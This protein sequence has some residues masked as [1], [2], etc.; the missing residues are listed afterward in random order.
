MSQPPNPSPPS[1][2]LS[3]RGVG[4]GSTLD[5]IGASACFGTVRCR[6]GRRRDFDPRAAFWALFS[7]FLESVIPVAS[8]PA[9]G[10]QMLSTAPVCFYNIGWSS[11]AACA[12]Y[13]PILLAGAPS[14]EAVVGS[15]FAEACKTSPV[16]LPS[17]SARCSTPNFTSPSPVVTRNGRGVGDAS[18]DPDV[19]PVTSF[20]SGRCRRSSAQ[21]TRCNICSQAST[22]CSSRRLGTSPNALPPSDELRSTCYRR[23]CC[24]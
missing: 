24:S 16:G 23:R 4:G 3:F 22:I 19:S 17:T 18:R 7:L 15:L 2:Y 5:E 21:G 12:T 13:L 11:L 14:K 10:P 20:M 9:R 8:P 1:L 6:A